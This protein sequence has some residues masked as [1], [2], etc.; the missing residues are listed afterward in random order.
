MYQ[1][2]FFSWIICG[3]SKISQMDGKKQQF[4]LSLNPEKIKYHKY[5]K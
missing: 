5:H 4:S 3:N 2:N 1:A